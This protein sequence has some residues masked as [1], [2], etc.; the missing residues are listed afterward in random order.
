[1]SKVSVGCLLG[2]L[3]ATYATRLR[4]LGT[5]VLLGGA[6]LLCALPSF[7]A[8]VNWTETYFGAARTSYNP[9]ETTLSPSNVSG[10]QQL[11]WGGSV[12]GGVTAFAL[13][14]GVIYAQGQG[15]G[16]GSNTQN[17][18]AINA[19]DG[20]TLW[21]ITTGN[22]NFTQGN[23]IATGNG[24]VFVGCTI[25]PE[26]GAAYGAVCA[27][28]KTHGHLKWS[29]SDTCNCLPNASVEA[30]PVY[31]GGAVY[32]GYS[33]GSSDPFE[34]LTAVDAKS[35]DVLW[36]YYTGA[37][38]TMGSAT[39]VIGN[40]MVYFSCSGNSF[41]GV[42]AA[43]QSDGSPAWTA[44]LGD[45]T[46][47]LTLGG[48]NVLYVNGGSLGE[49]VALNATTGATIW[50]TPG[51][52]SSNPVSLANGIIY[53]TGSDTFV[54][55]LHAFTGKPLWAANLASQSSVTIANGVLYD[56]QQGSN[57][58]ETAAYST[59]TGTLLWSSPVG[60]STLHPP[61]IVANGTLYITNGG[62]TTGDVCAYAL[63]TE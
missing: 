43:N 56:D 51:N 12:P 21:S 55:A 54:Y 61:P 53:A 10:L 32:F 2:A 57:N 3:S 22:P 45:A 17:L 25:T 34:S 62:C 50:S 29:Y 4:Q 60:A 5:C 38:N 48:N 40:G 42:C 33:N 41:S 39:P 27:Y 8:P 7:A 59:A 9:H 37:N 36:Q 30:P 49:F 35:G 14:A 58:P 11:T 18:V 63:P 16:A 44:N 6:A 19:T 28:S 24:L 46:I 20:T 13:D 23:T 52:S 1:M 15:P 26:M 31:S 47:G